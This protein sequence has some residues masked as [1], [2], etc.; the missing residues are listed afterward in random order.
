[1][2]EYAKNRGMIPV[3]ITTPYLNEY[4]KVI[5]ELGPAFFDDFYG[6]INKI[7]SSTGVQYF[8]YLQDNRF[9]SDYSL[10]FNTDHLNKKGAGKFTDIVMNEVV[11]V[12]Q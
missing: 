9:S 1:M 2:I 12:V 10:F 6:V 8:D 3:L 7:T 5:E 11:A 4:E